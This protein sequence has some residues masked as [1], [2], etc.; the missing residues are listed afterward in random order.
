MIWFEKMI[1][2]NC[3]LIPCFVCFL[4]F[5][6]LFQARFSKGSQASL[7]NNTELSMDHDLGFIVLGTAICIL[8]SPQRKDKRV[9]HPNPQPHPVKMAEDTTQCLS[10]SGFSSGSWSGKGGHMT[11][12]N[13]KSVGIYYPFKKK[14]VYL[15]NWKSLASFHQLHWL[16]SGLT[17][18]LSFFLNI[19]W[20]TLP[21]MP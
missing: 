16:Y 8:P 7:P 19:I 6:F 11:L 10:P 15:D 5:Y 20:L 14:K 13:R 2:T 18:H 21:H 9:F 3:L 17:V 4:P 1:Q 12:Y